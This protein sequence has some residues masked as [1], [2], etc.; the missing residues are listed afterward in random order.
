[1]RTPGSRQAAGGEQLSP[2]CSLKET[3]SEPGTAPGLR[4]LLRWGSCPDIGKRCIFCGAPRRR[5][6]WRWR[7]R[8]P[9]ARRHV[10]MRHPPGRQRQNGRRF[11][12]KT[13]GRLVVGGGSRTEHPE[14]MPE[15][16]A[17]LGRL[18][19]LGHVSHALGAGSYRRCVV[20]TVVG[21]AVSVGR[22]PQNKPRS[23][24]RAPCRLEVLKPKHVDLGFKRAARMDVRLQPPDRSSE[25]RPH[26][27][28]SP[29]GPVGATPLAL[30]CFSQQPSWRAPRR[31][32]HG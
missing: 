14:H 9:S 29:N 19:P 13:A 5:S 18:P 22:G 24:G 10:R 15:P 7:Q 27:G 4:R 16:L 28:A 6:A 2:L 32:R 31:R 8:H 20:G 17:R 30:P 1:M 26:V 12:R 25:L 21:S 23:D 3:D 11:V